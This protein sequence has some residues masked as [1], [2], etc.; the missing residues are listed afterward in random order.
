MWLFQ[1]GG[2]VQVNLGH[3]E[4]EEDLQLGGKQLQVVGQLTRG[5][6]TAQGCWSWGRGGMESIRSCK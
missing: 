3:K 4:P 5:A 1:E 2:Q 6:A